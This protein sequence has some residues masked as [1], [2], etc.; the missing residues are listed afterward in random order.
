MPLVLSSINGG[1]GQQKRHGLGGMELPSGR[2][3]GPRRLLVVASP[4]LQP[5]RAA[6][7]EGR[8]EVLPGRWSL[9]RVAPQAVSPLCF[10]RCR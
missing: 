10:F 1:W 8:R 2:A 9:P 6:G 5:R 7:G 4:R 3:T